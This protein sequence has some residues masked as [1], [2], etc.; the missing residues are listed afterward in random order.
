[1]RVTIEQ[2]SLEAFYK[3]FGG[4]WFWN[5]W[6]VGSGMATTTE[7]TYTVGTLVVDLFDS[8]TTN[9]SG[10]GRPRTFCRKTRRKPSRSST[11]ISKNSFG[12]FPPSDGSASLLTLSRLLRPE[13]ASSHPEN[14]RNEVLLPSLSIPCTIV[15][16]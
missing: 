3:G 13:I 11:R 7:E 2:R 1:M 14:A 5:H 15:E 9:S 10:E 4:G 6:R 12:R 16:C 8:R